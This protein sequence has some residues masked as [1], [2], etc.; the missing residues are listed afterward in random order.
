MILQSLDTQALSLDD[1]PEALGRLETCRAMLLSRLVSPPPPLAAPVA[2]SLL[3]IPQA[4]KQIGVAASYL[5]EQGRLGLFP[6]VRIGAKHVRV[7]PTQ[8]AAWVAARG[9]SRPKHSA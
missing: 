5:Y 3:T 2:A 9:T 1:I 8:L 7:D 4:A 6:T